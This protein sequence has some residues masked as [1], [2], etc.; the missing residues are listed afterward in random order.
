MKRVLRFVLSI[1]LAFGLCFSLATPAAASGETLGTLVGELIA[2][3]SAGNAETDILRVLDS[4]KAISADDYTEWKSIINYW[5]YVDNNMTEYTGVA[6]DGLPNTNKHAF[7]VLGY[8]LNADGS[9]QD[10]LKGRCD[11]AYASALKYPNSYI[12]VTGGGTA[13]NNASVTEG[14]AMY[15]YLVN[16]KGLDASRVIVEDSAKTTVQ[17]AQN[18]MTKLYSYGITSMSIIS[19]QYHLKRGCLLFYAQSLI[20]ARSTGKDAITLVGNAGWVRSDKSTEGVNM[21]AMSLGQIAQGADSTVNVPR[22]VTKSV[23][24]SIALSGTTSYK[25]GAALDAKVTATYDIDNYTR[26]VTSGSTITGYS[27]TTGGKQTVTA[28]YTENDVTQSATMDVN[29]AYAVTSGGASTYKLGKSAA[30]VLKTNGTASK[31]TGVKVDGTLIATD[32]YSAADQNVTFTKAYLNSLNPGSHKITLVYSDGEVSTTLKVATTKPTVKVYNVAYTGQQVSPKIVVK[33]G[34]MTLKKG[35]SYSVKYAQSKRVACGKYKV[36]ITY[37]GNYKKYSKVTKSYSIKPA[38]VKI[39]SL[40]NPTKGKFTVSYSKV[41]GNATYQIAYKTTS[42][43]KWHYYKH[44]GHLS[45]WVKSLKGKKYN[46]KVRAIEGTHNGS[47]S[48]TKTIAVQ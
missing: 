32:K 5:N 22:S 46:V 13:K 15:D 44:A 33:E 9:M 47:W 24:Q 35:T 38:T 34:S 37:K 2:Y 40:A 6:P 42:A 23:L 10:E 28:T 1:G 7:V 20:S 27:A 18:T 26:D 39:L 8:Q 25:N 19:S 12:F 30:L 41:A 14:G 45:F 11:V 31:L 3:Y 21:E 48:T 16:T 17:N 4:I 43:S 36:T 29:V